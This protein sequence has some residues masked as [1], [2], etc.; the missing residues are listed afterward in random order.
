LWSVNMG[1]KL[2]NVCI[3]QMLH[4]SQIPKMRQRDVAFWMKEHAI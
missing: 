4:K 1:R 2:K 3:Q